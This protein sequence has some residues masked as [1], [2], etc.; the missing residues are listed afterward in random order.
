[1]AAF[2]A[3]A[4]PAS[5]R[6]VASPPRLAHAHSRRGRAA[7]VP[8][9][10]RPAL[11]A[12]ATTPAAPPPAR[13]TQPLSAPPPTVAPAGVTP[14]VTYTSLDGNSFVLGGG[15]PA[16]PTVRLFIDPWLVGELKFLPAVP[17]F[18]TA[19]KARINA[20]TAVGSYGRIDGIVL[21]Q[22]LPDHL[23]VPTLERLD[24]GIPV[25]AP[26]S[27]AG[28][29]ADLG[30]T[31]VTVVRPGE[32][33]AFCGVA[34]E[35]TTGSL[36]GPPW[37]D[38]E[39]GYVFDF[40]GGTPAARLYYEPHGNHA[41]G[42]LR[43]VAD[44]GVGVLVTPVRTVAFKGIGYKLVNGD[45]ALPAVEAVGVPKVVVL[46]NT[47]TKG[48]GVLNAAIGVKGTIDEFVA[49]LGDGVEV[50]VPKVGEPVL[51]CQGDA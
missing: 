33:V 25:L 2:V 30:F 24:K 39:N 42:V 14:P 1:M 49:G 13:P 46:E 7:A 9:C 47:N 15:P 11:A 29:L 50:I 37:Q 20:D 32:A 48:V 36:V 35:A 10:P 6:L 8:R 17:N 31:A 40:G 41:E 26:P 27:A 51:L 28:A 5:R 44:V 21:T 4:A 45:D 38:P 12:M 34:I 22:A 23:H 3:A 18:Y 19:T 16:D 43:R